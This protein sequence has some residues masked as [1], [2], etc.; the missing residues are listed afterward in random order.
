MLTPEQES[1]LKTLSR[2][3]KWRRGADIPQPDPKDIGEAIDEAIRLMRQL[4][5]V[6]TAAQTE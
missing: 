4:R 1:A 2:Y 6:D 5:K 3:N